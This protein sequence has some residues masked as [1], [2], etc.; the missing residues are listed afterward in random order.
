MTKNSFKLPNRIY[1]IGSL[2][3]ESK[4]WSSKPSIEDLWMAYLVRIPQDRTKDE[5]HALQSWFYQEVEEQGYELLL[6]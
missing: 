2:V 1:G 3:A 4:R 5:I 6:M